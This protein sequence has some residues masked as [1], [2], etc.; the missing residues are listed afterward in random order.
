MKSYIAAQSF[1]L[2]KCVS[3]FFFPL[4]R[5]RLCNFLAVLVLF[6]SLSKDGRAQGLVGSDVSF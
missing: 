4:T 6:S 3:F 5:M 2:K 1:I